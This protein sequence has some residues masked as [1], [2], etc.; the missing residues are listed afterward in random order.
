MVAPRTR[1]Y[2]LERTGDFFTGRPDEP[3]SGAALLV[4]TN[5]GAAPL[6]PTT[7]TAALH[8][9]N[10]SR[11]DRPTSATAGADPWPPLATRKTCTSGALPPWIS[12][13]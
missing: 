10:C 1:T 8:S 7:S 13:D 6:R 2:I 12:N 9:L 4:P 3:C 5:S 11:V